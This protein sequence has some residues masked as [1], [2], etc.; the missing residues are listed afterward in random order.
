MDFSRLGIFHSLD[1]LLP[2]SNL[3]DGDFFT[4][5]IY[6]KND[7]STS[8]ILNCKDH[9]IFKS[10]ASGLNLEEPYGKAKQLETIVS[11]NIEYAKNEQFGYLTANAA[12]SGTGLKITIILFIPCIIMRG[13]LDSVREYLLE[14]NRGIVRKRASKEDGDSISYIY[15]DW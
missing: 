10:M 13:E 11:E 9:F 1:L 5:I 14:L 4:D 8:C 12:N 6:D 2:N 15:M 7:L 3:K